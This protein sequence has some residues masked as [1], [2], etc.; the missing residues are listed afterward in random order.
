MAVDSST[1]GYLAPAALPEPLDDQ[2]LRRFLQPIV[3]Q[4]TGIPGNMVRPRWQ[5]E[6]ANLPD[7]GTDW[8]AMG[9]TRR[10]REW[11]AAITHH[12]DGSDQLDRN[13][14]IELLCSFYGPNAEANCAALSDGLQIEQNRD[15]LFLNAMGLVDAS[16]PIILPVL[17]KQ[18]WT[19]RV[20]LLLTLRRHIQRVYPVLNI[21]EADSTIKVADETLI[22][23]P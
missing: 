12:S 1:S 15:A 16:E 18:R 20:D 21:A 5:A 2:A 13:E 17:I 19:Y 14:E 9:A 22:V 4:I 11:N 6:P 8:V 10:A 3:V 23:N 7:F